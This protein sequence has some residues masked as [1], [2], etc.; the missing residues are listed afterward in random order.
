[1]EIFVRY[2]VA[3]IWI[4]MGFGFKV[5][6][7]VPRHRAIV[8]HIMGQRFATPLTIA[9][10]LGE[11]AIGVWMATG[12]HAVTCVALQTALVVVMNAIELGRVRHLLLSPRRMVLLNAAWLTL[13]WWAVL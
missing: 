11:T 3:A 6:N 7:W 13:A 12:Y 9:I 8:A 4:V 10:G 1:M 5:L 2:G